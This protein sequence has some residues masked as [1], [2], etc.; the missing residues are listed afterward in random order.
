MRDLHSLGS[1]GRAR[2]KDDVSQIF[3]RGVCNRKDCRI[4]VTVQPIPIQ[5][6]RFPFACGKLPGAYE[7]ALAIVTPLD[8]P[9]RRDVPAL[10]AAPDAY[11]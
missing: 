6:N 4:A 9:E 5:N 3:R 2:C 7:E 1:T 8:I 11:A 10:Y